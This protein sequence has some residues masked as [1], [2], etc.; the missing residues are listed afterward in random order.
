MAR[1]SGRAP[2][3]SEV[4]CWGA[5][6]ESRRHGHMR[7][8][9]TAPILVIEDEPDVRFLICSVLQAAG[10]ATVEA[11][12]GEDALRLVRLE[13]PCL[14]ILDVQLPGVSGYEVCH[15]LRQNLGRDLPIVM[16]SGKRIESLDRVAG[17]LIGADDYLAKPFVID[18]LL[19]RVRGLIRRAPQAA[20]AGAFNLTEREVDVLRLLA[21]ALDQ[22]DIAERLGI[23]VKTV[24][25]HLEH[26]FKKLG[27]QSRAQAVAVAY[28]EQLINVEPDEATEAIVGRPVLLKLPPRRSQ[29]D[30]PDR[31]RA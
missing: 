5:I 19:A 7:S 1:G 20:K 2:I 15:E 31:Q 13:R 3:Q 18:E 28:R 12:T 27:V 14:V 4:G 11:H 10:Y 21:C 26:V 22:A 23:S 24:G 9:V 30:D 16:L 29:G 8:V 17:L 25:T 6:T